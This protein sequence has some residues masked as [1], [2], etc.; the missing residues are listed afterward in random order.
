MM[1]GI[2]SD[3]VTQLVLTP[4]Q[5]IWAGAL[6]FIPSLVAALAI[7]IIGLIVATGIA[8]LI[9]KIFE[10]VKLDDLLKN[11][12]VESYFK[13]AGMELNAARFLGQLGF[14]FFV[15]AFLLA[16]SDVLGLE[17]LSQFL[18][19]VLSYIPNIFVAVLIMLA[20]VVVANFLRT[21]VRASVK[22]AKLPA[23]HFLGSLVWWTIV[24]FGF[25]TVLSQL[26]I[27]ASVVNTLVSGFITMLALAGGLAFG[28]G[29]KD[30]AGHMLNRLREHTES[31]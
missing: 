19:Q 21:L 5:N 28:L 24:I 18:T 26:N 20:T 2:Y 16:S 23:A 10:V 30:Y 11:L 29:G 1:N 25:L 4:I 17:E 3:G 7:L 22:G 12:G 31:R 9:Q 14:W 13:R 6:G 27:A 8:A 15:I